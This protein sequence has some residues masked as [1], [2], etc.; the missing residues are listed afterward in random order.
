M[1]I[2]NKQPQVKRFYE[3][4][5]GAVFQDGSK[6]FMKTEYIDADDFGCNAVEL[7]TGKL[8]TMFDC[9]VVTLLNCNL[10]IE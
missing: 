1:K 10:V 8:V 4:E 6:I 3:L 7:E 9:A 5:K 2:I